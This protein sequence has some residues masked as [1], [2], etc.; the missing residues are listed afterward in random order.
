M[1]AHQPPPQTR[2]LVL[3]VTAYSDWTSSL[4]EAKSRANETCARFGEDM[5]VLAV[6]FVGLY[7]KVSPIWQD[8]DPTSG[9][10]ASLGVAKT[11]SFGDP[12]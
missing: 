7:E 1:N 8:A 4:D 11:P 5:V 2:Y 12:G 3:P 9:P 6:G 10:V